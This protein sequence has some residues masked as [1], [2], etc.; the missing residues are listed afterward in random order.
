MEVR[1]RLGLLWLI[2]WEIG[3]KVVG[4]ASVG[5]GKTQIAQVNSV[6]MPQTPV[7]G[8]HGYLLCLWSLLLLRRQR[9]RGIK[10]MSDAVGKLW[11]LISSFGE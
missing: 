7:L 1:S 6:K 5:F 3:V 8:Q 2:G 4:S 10:I 11:K 9:A